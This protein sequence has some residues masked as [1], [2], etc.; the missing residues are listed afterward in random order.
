MKNENACGWLFSR[1]VILKDKAVSHPHASHPT[2]FM[3][4]LIRG[5]Q[6][7]SDYWFALRWEI[8]SAC[9]SQ[10]GLIAQLK[11]KK[12]FCWLSQEWGRNPSRKAELSCWLSKKDKFGKILSLFP[13]RRFSLRIKQKQFKLF[14]MIPL[15]HESDRHLLE[16]H[17][18]GLTSVP[19]KLNC[20]IVF[21]I[22]TN[23]DK[24]NKGE[25]TKILFPS[26]FQPFD[27][28]PSF[29]PQQQQTRM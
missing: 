26:Y 27:W 23:W 9:P 4:E 21:Y 12:W 7:F 10:L 20:I 14:L 1:A 16:L 13:R 17:P 15:C 5:N 2:I 11:A 24:L 3:F 6:L 29:R 25:E 22:A 19:L 8:M 28:A 18:I